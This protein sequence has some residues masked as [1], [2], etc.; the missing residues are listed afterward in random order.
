MIPDAD[1]YFWRYGQKLAERLRGRQLSRDEFRQH[2]VGKSDLRAIEILSDDPEAD[3]IQEAQNVGVLAL[4]DNWQGQ[5][6]ALQDSQ[7]KLQAINNEL[8]Q[9]VT[10]LQTE[11]VNDKAAIKAG[12]DKIAD[13][14]A[15][16][17]AA[18]DQLADV[19]NGEPYE[20]DEPADP[21]NPSWVAKLIA[22]WLSRR[23]K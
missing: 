18:H 10:K 17:E 19:K 20:P 3:R 2:L 12:L 14:T 16:L 4:R 6:N 21:N 9:T 15:Q 8:N 22:W 1:N 11:D 5:I 23:K 13:L 7:N